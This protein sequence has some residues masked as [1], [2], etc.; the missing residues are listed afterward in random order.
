MDLCT[1]AEDTEATV[2]VAWK[3]CFFSGREQTVLPEPMQ[4]GK[5][6][7]KILSG[8]PI[9]DVWK[10]LHNVLDWSYKADEDS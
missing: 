5:K 3:V 8:H 9:F 2:T 1:Q 4:F 10:F 6:S 7:D